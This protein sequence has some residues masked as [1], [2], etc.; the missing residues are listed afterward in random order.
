MARLSKPASW[1]TLRGYVSSACPV[2]WP[3]NST[4]LLETRKDHEAMGEK[5]R[6]K[7]FKNKWGTFI[8]DAQ[9]LIPKSLW[10]ETPLLNIYEYQ[11]SSLGLNGYF[12][13][14]IILHYFGKWEEFLFQLYQGRKNNYNLLRIY[15]EH[16]TRHFY[17]Y[18][19]STVSMYGSWRLIC[20][21]I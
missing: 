18:C 12:F 9:S 11:P 19:L 8:K 6:P 10:L 5:T 15:N 2:A 14:L 7:W 1:Y 21:G 13:N 20:L 17:I 3:Y 4:G 16:Y